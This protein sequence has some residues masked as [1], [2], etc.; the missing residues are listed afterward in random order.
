[1]RGGAKKDVTIVVTQRPAEDAL[2]RGE[3]GPDEEGQGGEPQTSRKQGEEKL[4][5]RVAPLTP[6]VAREIGTNSTEGV[7]V[8]GVNPD[9][10]AANAG[11]RRGDLVIEVNRHPITKVE[12][13]VAAIGK[14]KAGQVAVLRVARG[15]QTVFVPVR[16]GGSK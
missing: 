1:V 3:S 15:Q 9:G 8:V 4:G 14:L 11:I 7:V 2:A 12:Q 16:L 6:D 10:P 5:L 13:L